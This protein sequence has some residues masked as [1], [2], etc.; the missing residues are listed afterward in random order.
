[1]YSLTPL[2]FPTYVFLWSQKEVLKGEMN[3]SHKLRNPQLDPDSQA[4]EEGYNG[5]RLW[6]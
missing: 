1:M 5:I 3:V 6:L 2:A 4:W